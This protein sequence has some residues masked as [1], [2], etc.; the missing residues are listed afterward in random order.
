[1]SRKP[2]WRSSL[3]GNEQDGTE[4]VKENEKPT[5]AAPGSLADVGFVVCDFLEGTGYVEIVKRTD[6]R[7]TFILRRICRRTYL[8]FGNIQIF[9]AQN[10]LIVLLFP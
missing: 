3:P 4:A 8:P 1:M 9:S 6:A 7:G 5:S 2:P 10:P